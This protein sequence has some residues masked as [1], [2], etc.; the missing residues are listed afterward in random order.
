MIA[1]LARVPF[2]SEDLLPHPSP[3]ADRVMHLFTCGIFRSDTLPLL[4]AR[5]LEQEDFR[6]EAVACFLTFGMLLR[7]QGLWSDSDGIGLLGVPRDR[8][9]DNKVTPIQASDSVTSDVGQDNVKT[10]DD[11]DDDEVAEAGRLVKALYPA[12]LIKGID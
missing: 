7:A 10:D 5:V 2:S 6:A 12:H 9:S 8:E 4:R 3:V 11:D 1:L